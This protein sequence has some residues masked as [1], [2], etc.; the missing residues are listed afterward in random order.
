MNREALLTRT[1]NGWRG[2]R[3]CGQTSGGKGGSIVLRE[4]TERTHK[5]REPF[6]WSGQ[7]L[8]GVDGTEAAHGPPP[9]GLE[10]PLS[11]LRECDPAAALGHRTA[12]AAV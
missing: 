1:R 6:P 7:V 9:P 2:T 4:G 5:K 11:P 8:P 12:A 3:V 10:R